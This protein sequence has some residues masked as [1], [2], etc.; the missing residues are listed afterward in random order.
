MDP[1]KGKSDTEIRQSLVDIGVWDQ[2]PIDE[3]AE[4]LGASTE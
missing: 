4:E 1:R 3:N 2:L